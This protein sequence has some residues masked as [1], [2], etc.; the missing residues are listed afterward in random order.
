M[1][2][3]LTSCWTSCS[4]S[5]AMTRHGL[6]GLEDEPQGGAASRA[7][8]RQL[9]PSQRWKQRK[10]MRRTALLLAASGQ[11]AA[12]AALPSRR[13][14]TRVLLQPGRCS[15]RLSDRTI[16]VADFRFRMSS[17]AA[18]KR[19]PSAA[20]RTGESARQ[21][22][23][24]R[25]A[26]APCPL[27]GPGGARGPL[28]CPR[29]RQYA[30]RSLWHRAGSTTAWQPRPTLWTCGLQRTKGACQGGHRPL[31]AGPQSKGG[32]CRQG[33]SLARSQVAGNCCCP[34]ASSRS[35]LQSWK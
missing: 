2:S 10:L 34:F 32:A 30:H 28:R 33:G 25:P 13:W 3:C 5:W 17:L 24:Q 15:I 20:A 23:R 11:A 6:V 1:T 31:V 21:S 26:V 27:Y 7:R 18:A 22:W 35:T 19:P 9:A 12:R 16:A 14:S 29:V 8:R 4:M